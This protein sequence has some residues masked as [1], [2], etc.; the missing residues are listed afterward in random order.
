MMGGLLRFVRFYVPLKKNN[1][2]I[3]VFKIGEVIF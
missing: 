3:D 2:W 1:K